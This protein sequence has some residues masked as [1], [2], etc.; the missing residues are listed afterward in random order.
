MTQPKGP[1]L[2]LTIPISAT[3]DVHHVTTAPS[4]FRSAI[5][6]HVRKFFDDFPEAHHIQY[7]ALNLLLEIQ[8]TVF[9]VKTVDYVIYLHEGLDDRAFTIYQNLRRGRAVIAVKLPDEPTEKIFT[10][11]LLKS[12]RRRVRRFLRSHNLSIT[13]SH[14][15]PADENHLGVDII[16]F[17]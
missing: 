12:V 10:G 5:E 4:F 17:D 14:I 9:N 13:D 2:L 8:G 3:E 6:A 16:A 1:N 15:I 7:K 11:K